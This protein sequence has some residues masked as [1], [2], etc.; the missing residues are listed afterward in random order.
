L[1][2]GGGGLGILAKR[3]LKFAA[4]E[5]WVKIQKAAYAIPPK[6]NGASDDGERH[7]ETDTV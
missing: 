3:S 2:K 5:R 6:T 7:A 4:Y 1:R